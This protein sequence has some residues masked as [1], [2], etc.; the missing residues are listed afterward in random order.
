MVSTYIHYMYTF[1]MFTFFTFFIKTTW[2]VQQI[3][4]LHNNNECLAAAMNCIKIS[5]RKDWN[6][7]LSFDHLQNVLVE[8]VQTYMQNIKLLF[9]RPCKGTKW[10]PSKI[11]HKQLWSTCTCICIITES[12][13]KNYINNVIIY[14]VWHPLGHDRVQYGPLKL[15]LNKL[16]VCINFLYV[17]MM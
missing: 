14:N 2:T 7:M 9:T 3:F 1:I 17:H 16:I 15:I 6:T 13:D 10:S 12:I 11:K 4:M 8:T 5:K